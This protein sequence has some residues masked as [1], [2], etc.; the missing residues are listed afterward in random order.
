MRD[1]RLVLQVGSALSQHV[2]L[3]GDGRER[4][5]QIQHITLAPRHGDRIGQLSDRQLHLL[6]KICGSPVAQCII[7]IDKSVT[8]PLA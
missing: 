6:F 3:S 8:V 2:A 7:A 1:N 4:V 5:L